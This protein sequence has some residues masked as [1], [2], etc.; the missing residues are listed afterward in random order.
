[1]KELINQIDAEL[2]TLREAWLDAVPAKKADWLAR[3]DD[4]LDRRNAAAGRT[5]GTQTT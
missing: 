2:R 4:A 1:M 5:E 3:I